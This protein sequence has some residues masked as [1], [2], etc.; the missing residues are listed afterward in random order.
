MWQT[1]RETTSHNNSRHAVPSKMQQLNLF[2][3]YYLQLTEKYFFTTKSTGERLVEHTPLL[4]QDKS[5]KNLDLPQSWGRYCLSYRQYSVQFSQ[6]SVRNLPKH[7]AKWQF[8][9]HLLSKR[10]PENG[11][12]SGSSPKP[13]RQSALKVSSKSVDNFLR[14]F[15]HRHTEHNL[16]RRGKKISENDQRRHLVGGVCVLQK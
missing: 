3:L 15:L 16:L 12:K 6:N 13:H 14:Y 5:T 4:C 2:T 9:P 8:M 7:A 1:E 11:P 10:I